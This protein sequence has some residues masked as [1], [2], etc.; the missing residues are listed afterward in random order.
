[1]S[2][3]KEDQIKKCLKSKFHIFNPF[4]LLPDIY[5][6]YRDSN[7]F[8]E[9]KFF[10]VFFL[11]IVHSALFYVW[12]IY[13]FH[14]GITDSSG[15]PFEMWDFS[16]MCLLTVLIVQYVILFIDTNKYYIWVY[17]CHGAQI[18]VNLLFGIIYGL[19]G[20]NELG[21]Y[22][23]DVLSNW[24]FWLTLICCIHMCLIP[25]YFSR[26][27]DFLFSDTLINNLR[28]KRMQNDFAKKMYIKKIEHMVKC[29][30]SLAKFKKIYNALD[31]FK[32]DNFA[33]RK[34]REIVQLYKTTKT[35]KTKTIVNRME[36]EESKLNTFIPKAKGEFQT[37][38]KRTFLRP[39]TIEMNE[40][41][42]QNE[43]EEED[44]KNEI[45]MN[46][47]EDYYYTKDMPSKYGNNRKTI[48]LDVGDPNVIEDEKI[49]GN[50]SKINSVNFDCHKV[51]M[52]NDILS[53]LE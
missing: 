20:D 23:F 34:M 17:L 13:P 1:M 27:F 37:E 5:R 50:D 4:S 30:R 16:T 35:A 36:T 14:Y 25:V 11:G 44:K 47:I 51:D 45:N 33:D 49:N 41:K 9:F 12:G 24:T 21:A 42:Q 46:D 22:T 38:S 43:I 15:K 19:C 40:I 18:L 39:P 8:N 53:N 48:V 6:E 31:E 32:A 7:P 3:L 10:T 28:N 2:L 26:Y 52:D 29:T